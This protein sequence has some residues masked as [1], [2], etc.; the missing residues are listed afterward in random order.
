MKLRDILQK[1]KDDF[2][3]IRHVNDEF[4]FRG[5]ANTVEKEFKENGYDVDD[6]LIV[7]YKQNYWFSYFLNSEFDAY[8]IM[9]AR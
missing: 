1:R 9:E 4:L 2:I 5:E 3:E 7:E 8:I 6:Y